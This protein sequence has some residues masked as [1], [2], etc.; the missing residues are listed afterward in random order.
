MSEVQPHPSSWGGWSQRP[1][2]VVLDNERGFQQVAQLNEERRSCGGVVRELLDWAGR[3]SS[4]ESHSVSDEEEDLVAHVGCLCDDR[5]ARPLNNKKAWEDS[6]GGPPEATRDSTI[7]EVLLGLLEDLLLASLLIEASFLTRKKCIA[8]LSYMICVP[9]V[10]TVVRRVGNHITTPECYPLVHCHVLTFVILRATSTI[11]PNHPCTI[12][13]TP[14]TSLA[15]A[16]QPMATR[17]VRAGLSG[18]D[19]VGGEGGGGPLCGPIVGQS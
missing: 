17:A 13:P 19:M 6:R 16:C 11:P 5:H 9:E 12:T 3:T 7:I 18:W 8:M 15:P 1:F 10:V 14:I 2:D 4:S